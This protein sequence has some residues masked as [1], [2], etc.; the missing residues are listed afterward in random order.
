MSEREQTLT[1]FT[2][3]VQEKVECVELADGTVFP[4]HLR[5]LAHYAPHQVRKKMPQFDVAVEAQ[6]GQPVITRFLVYRRQSADP[7]ITG[8]EMKELDFDS[9]FEQFIAYA[10]EFALMKRDLEA[11]QDAPTVAELLAAKA[12]SSTAQRG[13]AVQ[14][15]TLMR[16]AEIVRSNGFN[17]RNEVQRALRVSSRTASRYIA[18]AKRRG[19][20][21]NDNREN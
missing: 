6:D 11:T 9:L 7:P 10:A 15:E 21:D 8:A 20:L 13:R 12:A 18:E 14:E 5:L 1:I 16:V 2:G 4:R 17:P 19:M 3:L